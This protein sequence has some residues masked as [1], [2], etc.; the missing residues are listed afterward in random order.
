[1]N[2]SIPSSV[3]PPHAAQNPLIWFE[4]SLVSV[5]VAGTAAATVSCAGIRPRV[6][7]RSTTRV[8]REQDIQIV[9]GVDVARIEPHGLAQMFDRLV[10]RAAVRE[11]RSEVPVRLRRAG[12][13]PKR[14]SKLRDRLV[15][16]ASVG[17]RD[18]ED[19][20]HVRGFGHEGAE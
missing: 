18:A 12:I 17:E 2:A 15:H 4:L 19:V 8:K 11:R 3:Q 13:K 20:V 10:P 9:P 14:L 1:M 7:G 16:P 5:R 6:Y